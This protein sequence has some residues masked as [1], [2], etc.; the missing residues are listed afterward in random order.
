MGKTVQPV[1]KGSGICIAPRQGEVTVESAAVPIRFSNATCPEC[2]SAYGLVSC[3][4][5]KGPGTVCKDCGSFGIAI[6]SDYELYLCDGCWDK[7]QKWLNDEEMDFD[8][9]RIEHEKA[10]IA[11]AKFKAGSKYGSGK[12]IGG[13]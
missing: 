8:H 12:I 7:L 4:K 13:G 9:L 5:C 10:V 2:G 1:V 11:T 3:Q 6:M